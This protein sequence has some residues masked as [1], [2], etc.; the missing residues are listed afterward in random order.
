MINTGGPTGGK[1]LLKNGEKPRRV[2][3]LHCVGSRGRE[4]EYCSRVC[5]MFSLKLATLV[6]EYVDAEVVEF[7]RDMRSFGK[8]YEDF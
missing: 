7:Y 6:R 1:V 8:G 5:C 4:H 2:A 3:I